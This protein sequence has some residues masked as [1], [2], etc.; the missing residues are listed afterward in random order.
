[1]SFEGSNFDGLK[2]APIERRGE[3]RLQESLAEENITPNKALDQ[4]LSF[5]TEKDGITLNIDEEDYETYLDSANRLL[6]AVENQEIKLDSTKKDSILAATRLIIEE[7]PYGMRE[8]DFIPGLP[9]AIPVDDDLE[10]AA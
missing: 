5:M 9:D 1:M 3:D 7:T 8:K 10:R 2:R 6:C 4:V